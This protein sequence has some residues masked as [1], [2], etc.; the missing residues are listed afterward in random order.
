MEIQYTRS[1]LNAALD[2]VLNE[3]EMYEDPNFGFRV[4][5]SVPGVTTEVLNPRNTWAD[6]AAYDAQA[7]KLAR[8]FWE[9]FEQFKKSVPSHV[10]GAGPRIA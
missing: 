7:H 2:G 3:V 10:I 8:L 5:V 9:N 4:P 6:K 1:L